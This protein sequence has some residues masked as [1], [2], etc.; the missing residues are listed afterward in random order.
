MTCA[1]LQLADYLVDG[2]PERDEIA[3]VSAPLSD[4]LTGELDGAAAALGLTA[5]EIVLAALGRT[6]VR[7]I[8]DGVV[9]VDLPGHAGAVHTVELVCAGPAVTSASEMLVAVH[10]AVAGLSLHRMVHDIAV[11]AHAQPLADV[12]LVHA[13]SADLPAGPAGLGHALELRTHRR[14]GVL[15][16]EWWYDVRRFEAYTIDEMSEQFPYGLIELTSEA[17]A[18][19]IAGAELAMAH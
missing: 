16:L 18:P 4:V 5:E 10:R 12:L 8:G 3:V 15:V 19:V 2:R 11:D 17:S 7:A 6:I 13:E 14:D 1:N 9:A